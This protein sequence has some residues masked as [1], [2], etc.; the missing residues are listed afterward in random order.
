MQRTDERQATLLAVY[1]ALR[2]WVDGF[3]IARRASGAAPRTVQWYAPRLAEFADYSERR[4]VA[5]VEAVDAGL[6]REFLLHLQENG[7]NPGGVHGYFRAV[8]AFFL[9]YER[10]TEPDG[11]RNPIRK[12]TAPK[13]PEEILEPAS[14]ESIARMLDTCHGSTAGLRDRA[15]LL[16]L[17]D[18]G[19]RAAE[20]LAF[21]VGDFDPVTGAL[22]VRKGKGGKGRVVF[23]GQKARQAVRR[24][25]KAR[26]G[27]AG[28][29][30]KTRGDGRMKY[31]GLRSMLARRAK[32]A[33]VDMPSPHAFR[34]ACALA[35][36]RA[37]ADL[38]SLQRLLGHADLSVLRK[39]LKQNSDDLQAVHAATSPVD[40]AGL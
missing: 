32:A 28:P 9:W 7:H 40:R 5:T 18:A 24:Y 23:L 4:N 20:L 16:T 34:R 3:L 2:K 35:M 15:I 6:L 22:T 1:P 31:Y 11:W 27:V 19:V 37:G 10:E 30:F 36:L 8:R 29:L 39:Y 13:V 26:G 33:G 25:L 38:I 21:D 17:L 12:V 14:V